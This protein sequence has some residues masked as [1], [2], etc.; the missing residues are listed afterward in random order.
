MIAYKKGVPIG[1]VTEILC[2]QR[3]YTEAEIRAALKNVPNKD[4]KRRK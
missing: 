3:I 4:K 1:Q 2:E